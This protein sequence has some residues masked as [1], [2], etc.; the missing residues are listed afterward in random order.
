MSTGREADKSTA[1]NE[2]GDQRDPRPSLKVV[3]G[4]HN[5]SRFR[6]SHDNDCRTR[7]HPRQRACDAR[8]FRTLRIRTPL[9]EKRYIRQFDAGRF[10]KIRRRPRTNGIHRSTVPRHSQRRRRPTAH[11]RRQTL[12]R[13]DRH[14]NGWQNRPCGRSHSSNGP[15]PTRQ[16]R[17][18]RC[19]HRR[20]RRSPHPRNAGRLTAATT[21]TT[22]PPPTCPDDIT[23]VVATGRAG[24][25]STRPAH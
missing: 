19:R 22:S 1:P 9:R 14:R 18:G 8:L 3:A 5:C 12:A 16:L 2:G 6:R 7:G 4:A 13:Y 24:R 23:P 10:R 21:A 20:N 17:L 11:T 25:V 15:R